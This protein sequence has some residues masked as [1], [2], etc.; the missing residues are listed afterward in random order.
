MHGHWI[1]FEIVEVRYHILIS[2]YYTHKA[3]FSNIHRRLW[4]NN[5]ISTSIH[6]LT[7]VNIIFEEFTSSLMIIINLLINRHS[8]QTTPRT[9]QQH[10][11]FLIYYGIHVFIADWY[12]IPHQTHTHPL[13]Y[14]KGYNNFSHI[15]EKRKQSKIAKDLDI[16]KRVRACMANANIGVEGKQKNWLND[17]KTQ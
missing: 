6:W 14:M 1:N 12:N 9:H 3:N 13:K 16:V 4:Y 5:T 7:K 2:E 15:L 10:S 11:L 17:L 8:T